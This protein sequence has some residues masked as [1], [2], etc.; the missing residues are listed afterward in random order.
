MLTHKQNFGL[1]CF[2]PIDSSESFHPRC[3]Y[4]AA[5]K[6]GL[7]FLTPVKTCVHEL[8]ERVHAPVSASLDEIHLVPRGHVGDGDLRFR[9]VGQKLLLCRIQQHPVVQ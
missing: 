3:F 4:Q 7:H 1:C 6:D 9:G 5:S 8:L 2:N